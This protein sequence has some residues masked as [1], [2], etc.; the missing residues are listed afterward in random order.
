MSWQACKVVH[1]G[2]ISS[3]SWAS[4]IN[5]P[6]ELLALS[7]NKTVWIKGL[8]NAADNPKVH[9]Q[10]SILIILSIALSDYVVALKQQSRR[11][12]E[13]EGLTDQLPWSRKIDEFFTQN[14]ISF[15]S[16]PF[17]LSAWLIHNKSGI[18]A[19]LQK[20]SAILNEGKGQIVVTGSS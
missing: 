17:G 3:A 7:S 9:L 16:R 18:S 10:L 4:S 12:D 15:Q 19:L 11:S 20:A 1:S 5:R 8:S 2:N 14:L 6:Q 13:I